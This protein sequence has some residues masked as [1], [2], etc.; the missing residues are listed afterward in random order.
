MALNIY[1][2]KDADLSLIQGRKVSIIGYGSQGHAHANNLKDSGVEDFRFHDLRHSAA[3][4][5]AM[6]GA[7]LPEIAAI[8]GHKTLQMVQR[9]AHLSEDHTAQVVQDM[10]ER[11][12]GVGFVLE[13]T[14]MGM[15]RCLGTTRFQLSL[16]VVAEVVPMAMVGIVLGI[17]IGFALT[18]VQSV[19]RSM[20]AAFAPPGQSAEFYGFFAVAGPLQTPV[21]VLFFAAAASLMLL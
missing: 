11:A 9:Y 20:V 5:L 1:Y 12:R 10:K 16:M 15:L 13:L 6:N 2:D 7:T 17:P 4:Y 21:N 19:S 3:S 14:Q 18:G 8:L